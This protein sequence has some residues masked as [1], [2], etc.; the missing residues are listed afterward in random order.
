MGV[1]KSIL[2][3]DQD[4]ETST[5]LS[6]ALSEEGYNLS[7]VHSGLEAMHH[8]RQFPNLVILDP[9]LSDMNGLDLLRS[10]K[11]QRTELSDIPVFILNR[12][13]TEVDEIVS[14]EIGADDYMT[15]PVEIGR[16]KARIRALFRRQDERVTA[17]ASENE[18]ITIA[19]LRILIP[20]FMVICGE[21]NIG[22]PKKEFEIL[23]HL[24]K[25]RGRVVNRQ[26]LYQLVWG[27]HRDSSSR[28]IDVHIGRIRKRL[29]SNASLI[30]TVP[31]VGYKFQ[32]G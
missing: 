11:Q 29:N 6:S 19:N 26:M 8:L 30:E 15:K 25:N 22:F 14:L 18:E 27:Y 12:K 5:L 7:I 17:M 31:G 13:G 20:Q 9:Q 4:R 32:E 23:V 21:K 3:I 28:T 10:I 2:L 1:C 24:A 16:L